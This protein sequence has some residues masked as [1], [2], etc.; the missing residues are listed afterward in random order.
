MRR[1]QENN[2]V[3]YWFFRSNS[4]LPSSPRSVRTQSY[5][6]FITGQCRDP[7]NFFEYIYLVGCGNKF[8]FHHKFRID[9]GRPKSEGTDR[10]YSFCLWILWTKNKKI[11]RRSTWKHRVL[12]NTCIQHGREHQNTVYWVVIDLAIRKGLTFYQTRSNAIILQGT[13]PACC[14]PKVVR[15][16]IGD[17]SRKVYA[18]LRPPPKIFLETWLDERIGFRSCSTSRRQ[19]TDPTKPKSKSR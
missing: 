19:P 18:S 15:M 13:L 12:H 1:N 14:I 6:S 16:E 11:L 5:W 9:T 17:Y 7:E 8:T 2:T 3:L 10:Q 4:V